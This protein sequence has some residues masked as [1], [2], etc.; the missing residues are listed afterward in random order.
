[1]S[2]LMDDCRS[3][4]IQNVSTGRLSSC[5][6][7]VNVHCRQFSS[8]NE[9]HQV[10]TDESKVANDEIE[11]ADILMAEVQEANERYVVYRY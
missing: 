1:M 9:Q 8:Y 5:T 7:K 3:P 10:D 2:G 6:G 4:T 11:D